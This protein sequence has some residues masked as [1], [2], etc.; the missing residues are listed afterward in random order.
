MV[1]PCGETMWRPW[2]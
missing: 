1:K 2:G